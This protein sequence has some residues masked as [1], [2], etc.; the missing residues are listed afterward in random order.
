MHARFTTSADL[1][2]GESISCLSRQSNQLRSKSNT[3]VHRAQKALLLSAIFL[4]RWSAKATAKV[5]LLRPP[6]TSVQALVR[7]LIE[8][9]AHTRRSISSLQVGSKN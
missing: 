4:A 3:G 7:T 5:F 8:F 6:K 1:V 2:T 9:I